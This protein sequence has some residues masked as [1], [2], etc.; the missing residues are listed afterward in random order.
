MKQTSIGVT[1]RVVVAALV[2]S[3]V[4]SLPGISPGQG[5]AYAQDETPPLAKPVLTAAVPPGSTSV[6]LSWNTIAG[7]DGYELVKQDRSVGTWSDSMPITGTTYTDSS[8]TAGVSY[9]YYVRAVA[10]DTN[11]PWSNYREV[12]IPGTAPSAPSAAPANLTLDE[13]GVT[14]IDISWDAVADADSY[15]IYRWDG[16]AGEWIHNLTGT[17][18]QDTGLLAGATYSYNIRAV[19]AGG[20]GPWSG[21][22]SLAL[23]EV[24]T[25]PELTLTH[26][27]REVVDL[28]WTRVAGTDVEYELERMTEVRGGAVSDVDWTR[29]G[30]GLLSRRT[31]TDNEAVYVGGSTSTRYH[32]R[33]RAVVDDTAGEWSNEV[34]VA[35]P[36]TGSIP[37]APTIRVT[38]TDRRRITVSWD[39]VEDAAS[40]E[41]RFKVA[42]GDYSSPSSIGSRTSYSHTRLSEQTKYTYQVRAK[43]VN[44]YS[45]WSDAV[46][47]ETAGR[48]QTGAGT[49]AAPSNLRVAS[50]TDN[51]KPDGEKIGLKLSWSRRSGATGYKIMVWV[52]GL[53][54]SSGA[55]V[56]PFTPA[57][58]M[59]NQDTEAD[60][61]TG[62][63][64]ELTGTST[65]VTFRGKIGVNAAPP[66]ENLDSAGHLMLAADTSYY[67]IILAEKDVNASMEMSNWSAPAHGM[68]KALK[69][70]A[71]TDLKAI[72]T[73]STSIWLSWTK[74]ADDGTKNPTGYVIAYSSSGA[75]SGSINVK[76]TTYAH[77]GLRPGTT[78]YYRV[79]ATN[80]NSSRSDWEPHHTERPPTVSAKTAPSALAM[81]TGLRAADATTDTAPAIKV[82]W[83]KVTG[84]ATYEIQKWD[85]GEGKWQTLKSDETGTSLTDTHGE[86]Y[87]DYTST[88]EA[89]GTYHYLI[90]ALNGEITSPWSE[91]VAGLARGAVYAPVLTLH[92]TGQTIVRLTWTGV[93][94]ATGYE[95]E[96]QEGDRDSDYF[97][98]DRN[99]RLTLELN[100]NPLYY[101]HAGRKTG[102][103]YSYRMRAIL[104]HT[105]SDWSDAADD[106]SPAQV[107]TRP[108][109]P[110]L[111]VAVDDTT[112]TTVNLTWKPVSLAGE[113]LTATTEYAIEYRSTAETIGDWDTPADADF[114]DPDC[115]TV[116]GSCTA[117]IRGLTAGETYSFR[118][119]VTWAGETDG[120]PEVKSYWDYVHSVVIPE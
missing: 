24:S 84:A 105:K 107:V 81:P 29:I 47:G 118:I 52:P 55:P 51:S 99:A 97:N 72:T 108:A 58:R 3:L 76:G 48:E 78:Y 38:S 14:A 5:A 75:G 87:G 44:G 96:Y 32:Y 15:S 26:T 31:H 20:V 27:S 109:R 77:T 4:A 115:T 23:D 57:W 19:N 69:P 117:A 119:R 13:A 59:V 112:T 39:A 46:S 34:S 71:P 106:A 116:A 98:D 60:S 21:Y 45:E 100:A 6:D 102:T 9:G 79:R 11:G 30:G 91:S 2:L 35:I 103:R 36:A 104:P 70:D 95:L 63:I 41:L 85:T 111:T 37:A 73:G 53:T 83:G 65:S 17:T 61:D 8:V 90:R 12:T 50:A 80:S 82:S 43:N 110:D 113:S 68:A 101:V 114:T 18:H 66:S 33:V 88:V 7:A 28:E 16:A 1:C 74:P 22:Q 92:P 64:K 25:V 42:D 40:Y 67:F 89:G 49:L 86:T 56:D 120:A 93:S 54:D 62:V 10:G 94:G